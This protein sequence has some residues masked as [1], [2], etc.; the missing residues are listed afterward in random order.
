MKKVV[1]L[2]AGESGNGAALLAQQKGYEVWVSDF[3][4]IKEGYKNE[5]R[6]WGIDFEEG[7]HD[8]EKVL[9]A[10]IIIKSPGIPEKAPVIKAI[11]EKGIELISEIEW[12]FRFKG[13]SRIVAITGSNG[14]SV[15]YTQR[16]RIRRGY[17]RQYRVQLCPADCRSA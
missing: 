16:K 8:M 17:G 14:K 13:E 2:G 1:I 11:R 15:S 6:Q 4:L 3:G 5:L 9:S 10:D 12:G 7:G